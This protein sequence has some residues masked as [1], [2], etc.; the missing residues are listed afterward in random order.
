MVARAEFEFTAKGF[1]SFVLPVEVPQDLRLYRRVSAPF[2]V[3]N[4]RPEPIILNAFVV[5]VE[6]LSGENLTVT[7]STQKPILSVP[8]EGEAEGVID[9]ET[10]RPL[11]PEDQIRIKVSASHDPEKIS[12]EPPS[13]PGGGAGTPSPGPPP[14]RSGYELFRDWTFGT[15][16]DRSIRDHNQLWE[17]FGQTLHW[18]SPQG[19]AGANGTQGW[20]R[21]LGLPQNHVFS[22][23]TL[24]LVATL[25]PRSPGMHS[26]GVA[27][28]MVRTKD[29]FGPGYYLETR[30]RFPPWESKAAWPAFWGIPEPGVPWT[31]PSQGVLV[32]EVDVF[33]VVNKHEEPNHRNATF[34]SVHGTTAA[35]GEPPSSKH[36]SIFGT[37]VGGQGSRNESAGSGRRS[38]ANI[39]TEYH[40]YGFDFGKEKVAWYFD[41]VQ[42]IERAFRWV[43][44]K[45]NPAP[46]PYWM[47]MLAVGGQWP[48]YPND[49]SVFTDPTMTRNVMSVEFFRIWK[50][51]V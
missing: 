31:N 17:T 19:S 44:T 10:S 3:R 51:K 2:L 40:T 7:A 43:D 39:Y 34:H 4:P 11:S 5:E 12:I 6:V 37:W 42:I 27:S 14:V 8:A 29:H 16:P 18:D 26:G 38:Q 36:S 1:E 21:F 25:N 50:K 33:E 28:G 49:V 23:T 20:E 13:Q 15:N 30:C 32:L 46:A 45:G 48:G 9:I 24:D 35:K 41:D 47:I 22:P